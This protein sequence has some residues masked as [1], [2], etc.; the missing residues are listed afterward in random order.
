MIL[1]P[2]EYKFYK[3]NIDFEYNNDIYNMIAEPYNT[4]VEL[5]EYICKKIYP[6]VKNIHC[7][8]NNIDLYEKEDEQIC[9][10]FPLKKKLKIKLKTPPKE[11][12]TIKS[13]QCQ[14]SK[15]NLIKRKGTISKNIDLLLD[16]SLPFTK[17]FYL[18]LKNKKINNSNSNR[19]IN[20]YSKIKKRLLLF[21]TLDNSKTKIN[22]RNKL[23]KHFE[24]NGND[25]FKEEEKFYHNFNINQFEEY[26]LLSNKL[27]INEKNDEIENKKLIYNTDIKQRKKLKKLNRISFNIKENKDSNKN[28]EDSYNSRSNHIKKSKILKILIEKE[29]EELLEKINKKY[30]EKIDS[31]QNQ[32]LDISKDKNED[33]KDNNI[34]HIQN[35][36]NKNNCDNEKE[37][38]ILSDPNYMCSLC[39][40][41]IIKHYCVNCNQFLCNNCIEKCKSEKHKTIEIKLN[42]DCFE[43]V[44]TYGLFIISDIENKIKNIE[45]YNKD[46]KL[47]DIKKKRDDLLSML[48]EIINLYS[49]ISKIL[50][51][52][53]KEK[54]VKIS[55]EKYNLDT[56]K[57]K[58]DINGIIK[59]A[60][61]YIK[62]DK[63]YNFPKYKLLNLKYFFNLINEKEKSH[64]LLTEKMKVYSLNSTINANLEKS[65]NEVE[66]LLK[67]ISDKEKPFS[68]EG[69]I[70]DEYDRLIKENENVKISKEKKKIFGRRRTFAYD[71]IDLSKLNIP[72]FQMNKPA[73]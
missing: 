53:Y 34:N 71:S 48:N 63:N 24:S 1:S 36:D 50:N 67:K 20:N 58:E 31:N 54:E 70:K 33:I 39:K 35:N 64:Q 60:D 68:L 26:K 41:N 29:K 28:V 57:I 11:N 40:N 16:S 8:Y 59:K 65:I 4:L 72:G 55:Y 15:F 10:L 42:E 43:I 69:S 30:Q 25:Y 52:I 56:N 46:F 13:Y 6:A 7:F 47:Y 12:D 73:D 5:K 27:K 18:N 19:N 38:Q 62:S 51:I 17:N 37:N 32:N 61:S 49:L 9:M 2:L 45:E 66:E 44:N 21:S 22:K 14:K 23:F 3:I